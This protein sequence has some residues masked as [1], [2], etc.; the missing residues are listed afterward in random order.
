MLMSA[1]STVWL[2]ATFA[3]EYRPVRGRRRERERERNKVVF[4]LCQLYKWSSLAEHRFASPSL[5]GLRWWGANRS[6]E[7]DH[8]G[9]KRW[10]RWPSERQEKWYTR[11]GRRGR[12]ERVKKESEGEKKLRQREVDYTDRWMIFRMKFIHPR[13]SVHSATERQQWRWHWESE[14]ES[15][16]RTKNYKWWMHCVHIG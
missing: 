3:C 9:T 11:R 14:V 15:E 13:H 16:S 12:R 10:W 8:S 1:M 2:A 4:C 7:C 6:S 5:S